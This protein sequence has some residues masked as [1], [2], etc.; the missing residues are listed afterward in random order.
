MGDERA[1]LFQTDPPYAVNY[2]GGSHPATRANRAKAN[3]DKDWSKVYHEAG[4]TTFDNEDGG[5]DGGR[6]FYLAFYKVAIER[7]IA[8][9]A[10]WYCWHASARQAMLE[11]VWNEVGAFHHQQ[12]IWFKSRPVLTFSVYMWAH[13]PCLFGWVKGQKPLVDRSYG[14]PSTVWEVPNAE[15]ESSEHPTSKPNRLF[16]IP[17][18][19]HTRGRPLLRTIQRQRLAADRRRAARAPLLRDRAGTPLR[20]RSDRAMGETDRK[21]RRSDC[22]GGRRR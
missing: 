5:G 7:A 17:M 20:R 9:N 22:G 8:P 16:A 3:R 21:E 4:R 14:N 19:L 2:S 13:E 12:I 15:V 10:A 11:G 6:S 18:E 1:G